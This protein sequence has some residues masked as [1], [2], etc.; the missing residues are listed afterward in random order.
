MNK[1]A[2]ITGATAGIGLGIARKFAQEGWNLIITGRRTNRLD[3][4]RQELKKYNI[5]VVTL[6]FDIRDRNELQKHLNS[7]TDEWKRIDLLINNAGLAA[8]LDDFHKASIDDWEQMIDTNIKGLLYVSRIVSEWMVAAKTGHI[9]NIGSIA[10]VNTYAKGHVYCGTKHAV[11]AIT[12]GMR[13]DLSPL[14][15]KVSAVHPGL[16]ETE[17]SMVRFKGDESKAN[18]VYQGYDPLQAEDIAATVFFMANQPKHVNLSDVYILPNAQS[19]AY[20]THK[21]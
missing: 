18:P 21:L 19:N 12:E 5:R 11:K 3:D 17:F 7:L 4:L 20:Y 13:I 2:L 6:A 14:G 1:I 15:I 8:G 9:I 16:V 10:G